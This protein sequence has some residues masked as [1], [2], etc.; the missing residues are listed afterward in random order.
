MI[1]YNDIDEYACDWVENLISAGHLPHGKIVRHPIETIDA[2][3]LDG[4]TQAHFFSG[5]GGW[6]LALRMAG[7]SE[8]REVWTASCPCQP[9]SV[10]GKGLAEK[11]DRHLF[12]VLAGLVR[13]RRPATVFG[14]QVASKDGLKWL[15]GVH[16]TFETLG[17]QFAA[18]DLAAACVGAPHIRQRL[19]WVAN[20]IGPRLEGREKQ[21]ARNQRT[22]TKR[23]GD[24]GG[25]ANSSRTQ[26]WT[27]TENAPKLHA[28][29]K[30]EREPTYADRSSGIDRMEYAQGDGRDERR[31]ESSWGGVVGGCGIYRLADAAS[32]QPGR[33]EQRLRPINRS[34]DGIAG[35]E[36]ST[37]I[38]CL[39]GK[40]RRIE[41]GIFPLA[42]G[43]PRDVGRRF[44]AVRELAKGARRN[45]VCRL[46]GYGN[47]IVP[48]LAAEFIRAFMEAADRPAEEPN[49]P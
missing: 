47:A 29:Q 23:S 44:P 41:P 6:P 31:A 8:D 32:P 43:I 30:N 3:D 9:F 21:S 25:L 5:I 15:A 11:D 26:C 33:R 40:R 37:E 19:Y 35:W 34:G 48:T 2:D 22:A 13:E 28:M 17:Y 46:K 39:D 49:T 1:L 20:S 45:R 16:D 24:A 4:V 10:A 42:H 7:W 38:L 12:P 27:G 36:K 14:E 18:V